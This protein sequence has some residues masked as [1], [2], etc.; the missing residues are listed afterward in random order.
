MYFQSPMIASLAAPLPPMEELSLTE[1]TE[2]NASAPPK[3]SKAPKVK[4]KGPPRVIP[5]KKPKL[6]KAERR[7]L[8]VLPLVHHC[9]VRKWL[10]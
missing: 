2:A 10:L 4:G 6:S 8:Q 3:A 9:L 7:A 1:N 5:P